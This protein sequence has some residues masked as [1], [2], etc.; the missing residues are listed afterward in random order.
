M[1]YSERIKRNVE[2]IA[3]FIKE[4]CFVDK[5]VRVKL[6]VFKRFLVCFEKDPMKCHRTIIK[7]LLDMEDFSWRN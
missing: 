6:S 1:K 7:E 3:N 2:I 5:N 4:N